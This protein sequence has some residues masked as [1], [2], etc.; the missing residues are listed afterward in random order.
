MP[1]SRLTVYTYEKLTKM[2]VVSASERKRLKEI[3]VRVLMRE[4]KAEPS[5]NL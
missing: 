3:E 4:S 1:Q 2:V 5:T